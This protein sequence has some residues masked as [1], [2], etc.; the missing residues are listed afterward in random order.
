[1]GESWSPDAQNRDTSRPNPSAASTL[2]PNTANDLAKRIGN[3]LGLSPLGIAGSALDLIDATHHGDL[4]GAVAAAGGMI[5]DAKGVASVTDASA[6]SVLDKLNRYLLNP[7]HVSGD[8]KANWFKQA[9]GF[10]RKNIADLAK[11]MVFDESGSSKGCHAVWN[12]IQSDHQRH[13]CQRSYDPGHH[14]LDGRSRWG[15][16]LEHSLAEERVINV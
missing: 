10:T 3:V 6:A 9:L 1:V 13:G 4:P 8:P 2:P 5:P 7:D 14:G 16:T 12:E 11:Q 15:A